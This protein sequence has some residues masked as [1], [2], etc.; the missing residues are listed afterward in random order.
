MC[1]TDTSV[2]DAVED[3]IDEMV[4]TEEQGLP[5]IPPA[6]RARCQA[7]HAALQ[8]HGGFNH[9]GQEPDPDLIVKSAQQFKAFLLGETTPPEAVAPKDNAWPVG[10]APKRLV[11]RQPTAAP[12]GPKD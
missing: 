10:D 4:E 9:V 3:V 6:E 11:P 12:V 7:L 1:E 5:M 2:R 8:Y